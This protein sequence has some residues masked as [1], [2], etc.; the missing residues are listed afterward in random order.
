MLSCVFIRMISSTANMTIITRTLKVKKVRSFERR[1]SNGI[2]LA[3]FRETFDD[4]FRRPKF[5]YVS[6][7][8]GQRIGIAAGKLPNT[9]HCHMNAFTNCSRE[10]E[11]K[12]KEF[13]YLRHQTGTKNTLCSRPCKGQV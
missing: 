2:L 10:R 6:K 3:C 7:W 11:R 5:S 1:N 9:V 4:Y 8:S 13:N 12:S